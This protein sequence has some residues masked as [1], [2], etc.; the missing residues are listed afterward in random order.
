[1][2][3]TEQTQRQLLRHTLAVIA[4]R[5]GKTVAHA[6]AEFAA[7]NAEATDRTPARILAHIGDLFDWALGLVQGRYAWHDSTP[8]AWEQEVARFYAALQRFDE[9]LASDAPL[10][11][12]VERLLQGPLADALTHVGQ[13][14][15]LRRLAGAPIKGENYFK[16]DIVAGRLGVEQARPAAEFE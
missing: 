4:Y 8:L 12:P 11:A 2:D 13:L 14:A 1:M 16:A 3:Q 5:G 7:F 6:P 9:Y 10:Q 15:M